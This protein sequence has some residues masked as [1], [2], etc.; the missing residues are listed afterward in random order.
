MRL[1]CC[2]DTIKKPRVSVVERAARQPRKGVGYITPPYNNKISQLVFLQSGSDTRSSADTS[3]VRL[4][5]S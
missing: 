2:G 1:W 5:C 4:T 3:G